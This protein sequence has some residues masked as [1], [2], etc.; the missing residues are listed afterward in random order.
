MM[1]ILKYYDCK[2]GNLNFEN[3]NYVYNSNIQEEE[4]AKKI[5]YGA[6]NYNLYNSVNKIS[7]ELYIEF[8]PWIMAS[9]RQDIY[10][11]CKINSNDN[12]WTILCKLAQN[13][14]VL[15]NYSLELIK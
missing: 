12:K 9:S 2:L 8:M 11:K 7:K 5:S 4:K 10:N 6:L 14:V 3:N 15:G 1:L 13:K